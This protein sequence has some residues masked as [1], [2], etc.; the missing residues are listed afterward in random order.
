MSRLS[1]KVAIVT[2]A[3]SGI[4][5]ETAKL[6]AREG[7]KVVVADIVDTTNTVNIIK[8]QGG[9]AIGVRCDV[10]DKKQVADMVATAVK[11]FGK[12][13]GVISE[14]FVST[15]M[16]QSDT[17]WGKLLDDRLVLAKGVRPSSGPRSTPKDLSE[18]A[19]D[20]PKLD[21]LHARLA[22]AVTR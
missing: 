11:S 7:A 17:E 12:V 2:G 15:L 22:A 10:L 13:E 16:E 14:T 6:F 18:H 4:G 8:Q 1:G 3:S 5:R 21:G 20:Q 9:V 19:G